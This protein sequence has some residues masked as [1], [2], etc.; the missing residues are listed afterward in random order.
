MV[1]F[2]P[3]FIII[4]NNKN[5]ILQ[6]RH[7]RIN[8]SV[9]HEVNQIKMRLK[10]KNH[11]ICDVCNKNFVK[12][13]LLLRHK[14]IHDRVR[15]FCCDLCSKK[16]NQK[17]ILKTHIEKIHLS[18]DNK[19]KSMIKKSL[20][21]EPKGITIGDTIID[22]KKLQLCLNI[23]QEQ[24]DAEPTEDY[25]IISFDVDGKNCDI[26]FQRK[27]INNV[28]HLI[29]FYC[30]KPFRKSSDLERHVLSHLNLRPY[31]CHIEG[32][33][34][35]FTHKCTLQRHLLI[36]NKKIQKCNQCNRN[37]KS[38][39]LLK[40][41]ITSHDA[42][43]IESQKQPQDNIKCQSFEINDKT[44]STSQNFPNH[45][46]D[47]PV[48]LIKIN[49]YPQYSEFQGFTISIGVHNNDFHHVGKEEIV[50][51]SV[52]GQEVVEITKIICDKPKKKL[53]KE[54]VCGV[55]S[56]IFKKSNDLS[57]HLRIHKNERPFECG[58]CD[59]KFVLKCTLDRH[60]EI[61]SDQRNM[62]TCHI[63]NQKLV[64]KNGL[65]LHL[66]IHSG[67]KDLPC[68]YE[69]CPMY[70]RTPGNLNAHMKVHQKEAQKLGVDPKREFICFQLSLT[71]K[72]IVF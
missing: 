14:L 10:K 38:L 64:S 1:Y 27:A 11:H 56:K 25:K 28:V 21:I 34:K 70:F 54:N 65:I 19:V 5:I 32:C 17:A 67:T 24:T 12:N 35:M 49:D 48:Q 71:T 26:K 16:F 47:N 63:C 58:F 51:T 50:E 36:H 61:H 69:D 45:P 39:K 15:P 68:R 62:V 41:H 42:T 7:L 2:H 43:A 8:I 46:N 4:N 33:N 23:P 3:F 53:K 55:C 40:K 37:Y 22:L 72:L 59:K 44:K 57:R 66:K 6:K 30:F 18:L 13:S 29:C 20:V 60:V 31:A 52:A 9:I